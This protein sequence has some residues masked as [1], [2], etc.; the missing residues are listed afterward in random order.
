MWFKNLFS[1]KF[2]EYL[3][4]Q[5]EIGKHDKLLQEY[6]RRCIE[7]FSN[8]YNIEF[9]RSDVFLLATINKDI[10]NH[11]WQSQ[12]IRDNNAN[13]IRICISPKLEKLIYD[14]N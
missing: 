4:D 9:K 10:D 14:K 2:G 11:I 7:Y 6:Q 3:M 12:F 5:V 8:Y 13:K 1:I